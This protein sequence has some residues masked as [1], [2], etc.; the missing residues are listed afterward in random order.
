MRLHSYIL[1]TPLAASARLLAYT[2]LGSKRANPSD[3]ARLD[4]GQSGGTW[5]GFARVT[6]GNA[7]LCGSWTPAAP[8]TGYALE[9]R[10]RR[11]HRRRVGSVGTTAGGAIYQGA[12]FHATDS[13]A[14]HCCTLPS[15]AA[16]VSY[17]R[18]LAPREVVVLAR[19]LAPAPYP[20][21]ILALTYAVPISQSSAR[22]SSTSTLRE[23]RLLGY[24]SRPSSLPSLV[25]TRQARSLRLCRWSHLPRHARR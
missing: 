24:D 14:D 11:M 5:Q 21:P 3:A 23:Q 12:S 22:R 4:L 20:P 9:G 25:L 6:E 15:F 1:S 10:G 18:D 19:P 8:L 7:L 16:P 2:S 17:P 13:F